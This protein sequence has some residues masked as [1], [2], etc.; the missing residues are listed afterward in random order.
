MKKIFLF[1]CLTLF[2][3]QV[4]FG[5]ND[6]TKK[7]QLN[8]LDA[9]QTFSKKEVTYQM[10]NTGRGTIISEYN[11]SALEAIIK[12]YSAEVHYEDVFSATRIKR[13]FKKNSVSIESIARGTP[14]TY[15]RQ[16]MFKEKAVVFEREKELWKVPKLD[17]YDSLQ[18]E[19]INIFLRTLNT[20]N[21]NRIQDFIHPDYMQIGDTFQL[22]NS[23][24]NNFFDLSKSTSTKGKFTLRNV[25][26]ENDDTVA[27]FEVDFKIEGLSDNDDMTVNFKGTIKRSISKFYDKEI[28]LH[29]ETSV[30]M[31]KEKMYTRMP[32]TLF[33]TRKLY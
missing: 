13:I 1:V 7:Y 6:Q 20:G 17:I 15:N 32:C 16:N 10:K 12:K 22:K 14:S 3:Q 26:I 31:K 30:F 19:R 28:D 27:I 29:G 21:S 23:S 4:T 5:Q 8:K 11:D 18:R 24:V 9:T 33:M 2:F 25:I